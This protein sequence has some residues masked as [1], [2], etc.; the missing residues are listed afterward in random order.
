MT[1]DNEGNLAAGPHF[2]NVAPTSGATPFAGL[3]PDTVLDALQSVGLLGDGRLMQLNSFENRVFQVHLEDGSV[4]VA[5]F[6]RPG[7]WSDEQI[8]EEHAFA[9]ELAA[10]EIPVIAPWPLRTRAASPIVRE[11]DAPTQ[12]GTPGDHL[13][14]DPTLATFRTADGPM[15]FAVFPR[16][17]GRAPDLEQAEV[18]Q[19]IGRY[20]GR[21]HQVGQRQP[22]LHRQT[23]SVSSF[24]R[25]PR[26]ELLE[27]GRI[28]LELESAWRRTTDELL[29]RAEVAFDAIAAPTL[30]LHGDA[31]AG[32]VL[33]TGDG[34]HFVDLDDAIQ[35]PAVQDLW[36]LIP[37]EP[38]AARH[39]WR[40]LLAGYEDFMEFDDAQL[41][42]VEPL[43]SLRLIRHNTWIAKRWDDPAFPAAFPWFGDSNYWRQQLQQL[44][45]Q[46][47]LP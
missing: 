46:L 20:L 23:L 27:L 22:F 47:D 39:A 6:Y 35:G 25:G 32:N 9:C 11:P 1:G 14:I 12:T 8:L 41:G 36:M 13:D 19:R 37:G 18:L 7:R 17:A 40:E 2:A 38:S 44:Q 15:R 30:R 5:K 28:P 45:E 10:Q 43:R 29:A 16:R 26:D 34:P 33:W 4:M 21:I 3:M 31:H 24:G 42:L